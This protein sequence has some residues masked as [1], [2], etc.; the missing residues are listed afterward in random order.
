MDQGKID[1][2][3]SRSVAAL[4]VHGLTAANIVH[5][6]DAERAVAIVAEEILVRLCLQDRPD[7][8]NWRYSSS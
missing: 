5:E 2:A 1:E 8:R 3:W 4:A 6:A 7:A